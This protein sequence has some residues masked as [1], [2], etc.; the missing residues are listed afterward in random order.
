MGCGLCS[1]VITSLAAGFIFLFSFIFSMLTQLLA[2]SV[3]WLKERVD[4]YS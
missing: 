1:E 3:V 2:A 4:K